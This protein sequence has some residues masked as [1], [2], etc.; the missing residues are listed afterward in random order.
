MHARTHEKYLLNIQGSRQAIKSGPCPQF[1]GIPPSP[2]HKVEVL[3][4]F[5][6]SAHVSKIFTFRIFF[7][8]YIHRKSIVQINIQRRGVVILVLDGSRFCVS[9]AKNG[10]EKCECESK[11]QGQREV[12]VWKWRWIVVSDWLVSVSR[13]YA[14]IKLTPAQNI[15]TW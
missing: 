3:L 6:S 10:E 7:S 13:T 2:I 15:S 9:R 5:L 8:T 4:S 11:W 14:H 12:G 1:D